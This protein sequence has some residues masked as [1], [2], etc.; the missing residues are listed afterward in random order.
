MTHKY[1]GSV[2]IYFGS[3]QQHN[4]RTLLVELYRIGQA[5]IAIAQKRIVIMEIRAVGTTN[6]ANIYK[7]KYLISLCLVLLCSEFMVIILGWAFW[8]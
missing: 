8:G 6:C 7:L 3:I 1:V 4:E 2:V 5:E